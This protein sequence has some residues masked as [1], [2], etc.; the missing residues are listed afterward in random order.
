MS[1]G[2][3]KRVE[4]LERNAE[5]VWEAINSMK[6][7]MAQM[8]QNLAKVSVTL[9]NI[10]D[11]VDRLVDGR[12]TVRCVEHQLTIAEFRKDLVR[13][14]EDKSGRIGRVEGEFVAFKEDMKKALTRLQAR[15]DVL[16]D[17][18]KAEANQRK[19]AMFV[20][21]GVGAVLGAVAG[22]L[23]KLIFGG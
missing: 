9:E 12:G 13:C 19:G 23:I 10:A 20:V 22:P 21:G 15:L 1:D 6:E 4:R 16:E 18:R 5:Q 11:S 2:L 7:N 8:A 3:E 17:A 14:A